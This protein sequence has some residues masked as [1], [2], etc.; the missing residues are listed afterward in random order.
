MND[1]SRSVVLLYMLACVADIACLNLYPEA[2]PWTKPWLMP[3]LI[4]FCWTAMYPLHARPYTILAALAFSW[5][6]DLLLLG[7]GPGWFLA[8]LASFLLAH[9]TYI[10]YFLSIRSP[11]VSFLKRRPVM[12][13]AVGVF[14]FELLH[15]LWPGLGDLRWAVT[16]YAVVIGTMLCCA[17]WQYG[18]IPNAAAVPFMLGAL[19]FVFSDAL[20]A[21]DRFREPFPAAGTAIMATYCLAQWLL[22]KGS[23]HAGQEQRLP[24]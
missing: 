3:L 6:G 9:L 21:I 22:V 15:I 10:M 5:M 16:A 4:G 13:L 20:L 23:L 14:V 24:A 2:R 1:R 8:G 11:K 18:K 12:L 7:K 17:L 19:S